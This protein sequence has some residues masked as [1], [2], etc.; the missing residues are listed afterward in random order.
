MIELD[1]RG[2]VCPAPIIE[3]AGRIREVATGESM[4]D[5]EIVTV[6]IMLMPLATSLLANVPA[7]VPVT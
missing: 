5:P 4:L 7:A 6:M 1:C 2:Q 3:L